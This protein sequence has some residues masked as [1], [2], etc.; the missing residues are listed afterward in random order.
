[1]AT[2]TN[3][4]VSANIML[5][6][7]SSLGITSDKLLNIMN[8]GKV[9]RASWIENPHPSNYTTNGVAKSIKLV[10]Y[11]GG[12]INNNSIAAEKY[13]ISPN[14]TGL[15]ECPIPQKGIWYFPIPNSPYAI[16][17]YG[18]DEYNVN[19]F[20][21]VYAVPAVLDST[22]AT[23]LKDYTASVPQE[24]ISAFVKFASTLPA[25]LTQNAQT[26]TPSTSKTK[27]FSSTSATQSYKFSFNFWGNISGTLGKASTFAFEYIFYPGAIP[28]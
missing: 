6:A 27:S 1:M 9:N 17:F 25:N 22:Y 8:N 14:F 21:Y 18:P 24:W 20:N 19:Y 26:L 16:K 11:Y 10:T 5:D 3:T 4:K 7:A 13:T 12:N 23:G 15:L 2:S 28:S